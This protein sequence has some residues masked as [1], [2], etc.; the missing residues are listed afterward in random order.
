VLCGG[1]SHVLRFRLC[2]SCVFVCLCVCVFVCLCCVVFYVFLWTLSDC[3]NGRVGLIDH[4]GVVIQVAVRGITVSVIA[5]TGCLFHGN[6]VR[7]VECVS[8]L[9]RGKFLAKSINYA[10][11]AHDDFLRRAFAVGEEAVF[12]LAYQVREFKSWYWPM[13]KTKK[14]RKNN[15]Q[16]CQALA[17]QR[18]RQGLL[19]VNYSYPLSPNGGGKMYPSLRPLVLGKH[20]FYRPPVEQKKKKKTNRSRGASNPVSMVQRLSPRNRS[21]TSRTLTIQ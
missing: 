5:P 3:P 16:P 18:I 17:W 8:D 12:A 19:H 20:S 15:L 14:K 6:V 21:R 4:R 13:I 11:E 2:V 7:D 10:L 9:S 1:W